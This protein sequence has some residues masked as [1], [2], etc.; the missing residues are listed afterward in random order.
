MRICRTCAIPM[1]TD[2]A[3]RRAGI[4]A[5]HRRHDGRELCSACYAVARRAQALIDFERLTRPY[6]ET[7]EE[8]SLLSEQGYTLAQAEERLGMSP[9]TLDRVIRRAA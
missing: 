6:A 9:R 2:K 8:W 5:G 1:V 4:P 3:A 7:L